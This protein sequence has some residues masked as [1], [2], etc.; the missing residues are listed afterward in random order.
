MSMDS[1]ECRGHDRSR[2]RRRGSRRVGATTERPDLPNL[3]VPIDLRN[4][5]PTP[6]SLFALAETRRV[7]RVAGATV[8]AIVLAERDLSAETIAQLGRAGA[9]KVLLCEGPSLGAPPLEATHGTALLAA[10]ERVSPLLVLFPAGGAGVS[11][12]PSLAA[13]LGAAFAGPADLEVNTVEDA[14]PDGVGRVFVRF[15]GAGRTAYR[16]LDPVDVE[17]PV[18][19]ILPAGGAA[20]APGTSAIDHD[21]ITCAPPASAGV[22]TLASEPDDGAAIALARV[23]VVVDPAL[24][25]AALE[26]L[27][28]AAPA[29]V[30]VADGAADTS[31]IAAAT[32]EILIV[33]GGTPPPIGTPRARV[34]LVATD[35]G[36]VPG[37]RAV[38][39][40]WRVPSDVTPD[41]M[42]QQLAAALPG[43]ALESAP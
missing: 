39:V 35:A 15:W 33:V 12:G 20:R 11:L 43:L 41:L 18:V 19:A 13:R 27:R 23:L 10:I 28:A 6:P 40:V 29:G 1:S 37:G 8:Y 32:P 3:L 31:S 2:L 14:L 17:R 24:G 7:A 34:A 26:T 38:D 4:A 36:P 25:G 5:I 22:E 16:R 30:A 42:I 21:V 9:D